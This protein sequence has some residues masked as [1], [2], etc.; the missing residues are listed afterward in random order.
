MARSFRSRHGGASDPSSSAEG[1][2][3]Q[4][5][6]GDESGRS[7][8]SNMALD[9][10]FQ[11][12]LG[13]KARR[14]ILDEMLKAAA[15]AAA[16]AAVQPRGGEPRRDAFED[17]SVLLGF[18]DQFVEE[19]AKATGSSPQGPGLA[20]K[21]AAA[22]LEP[23]LKNEVRGLMRARTRPA[24]RVPA[25][26]CERVLGE[27]RAALAHAAKPATRAQLGG[28]IGLEAESLQPIVGEHNSDEG[29]DGGSAGCESLYGHDRT[30]HEASDASVPDAGSVPPGLLS[31]GVDHTASAD[32]AAGVGFFDL[33]AGERAEAAVQC[34][35][36]S[37]SCGIVTSK[38]LRRS[39]GTQVH[40]EDFVMYPVP[41]QHPASK[42]TATVRACHD[43]QENLPCE[44][45]Y[46]PTP[47]PLADEVRVIAQASGNYYTARPVLLENGAF[48]HRC[49]RCEFAPDHPKTTLQGRVFQA[50]LPVSL[51]VS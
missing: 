19:V 41:D 22:N 1:D 50:S 48:A 26:K 25:G 20:L 11:S 14:Y 13:L 34:G 30:A 5:G 42:A 8:Q 29:I 43:E 45:C 23:P 40:A 33:A 35:R 37:R 21:Q 6:T 24:H 3:Q 32:T 16:S 10:V 27:V 2:G 18:T 39:W 4:G 7:D 15:Q 31:A 28:T 36:H 12:I 44:V 51:E 47:S 17:D 49:M 9:A 46:L 38:P